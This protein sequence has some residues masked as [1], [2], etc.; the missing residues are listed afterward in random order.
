VRRIPARQSP[1]SDVADPTD[2]AGK[3]CAQQER[4]MQRARENREC[5]LV[6]HRR[7]AQRYHARPQAYVDCSS[8]RSSTTLL[9][10][11]K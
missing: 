7:D 10:K 3:A 2:A 6:C 5:S 4:Q 9:A 8:Q 11:A 1:E